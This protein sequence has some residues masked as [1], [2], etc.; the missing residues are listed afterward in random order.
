M[1][2]A[3]LER[4]LQDFLD[5]GSEPGRELERRCLEAQRRIVDIVRESEWFKRKSG[6]FSAG[7]VG[8]DASPWDIANTMLDR[9]MA[10]HD[11]SAALQHLEALIAAKQVLVSAV[12]VVFGVTCH[13]RIKLT[14]KIELVP[15]P[16]LDPCPQLSDFINRW[17]QRTEPQFARLEVL[18]LRA[19]AL[20]KTGTL[21][22]F[23][24]PLPGDTSPNEDVI[25]IRELED[26]LP[27]FG[28]LPTLVPEEGPRWLVFHDP[29]I[30]LYSRSNPAF[31]QPFPVPPSGTYP[32][33]DAA[34]ISNL[35]INFQ[36]MP[37]AAGRGLDQR[38]I[39]RAMARYIRS[40]KAIPRLDF[41]NQALDLAIA[42]EALTVTDDSVK[43]QLKYRI[44]VRSA[45]FLREGLGDRQAVK[46]YVGALYDARSQA[47]H[48]GEP[49]EWH[50]VLPAG[51]QDR[52]RRLWEVLHQNDEYFVELVRK[53]LLSDK[54]PVW[55]DVELQ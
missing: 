34:D 20:V 53:I 30:Q 29:E 3:E 5:S 51:T 19:A 49:H 23:R 13:Q 12:L 37:K 40:K 36:R 7:M 18:C 21:S 32:I 31:L 45:R 9:A 39:K 8:G 46:A 27:L 14:D 41:A 10:A 4:L 38:R 54:I 35:I 1:N 44:S 33:T 43:E 28:I 11:V 15:L 48:G 22:S 26:I 16:E 17:L 52:K 6:M 47:A 25:F 55:E 2:V 24:A 42:F 50:T